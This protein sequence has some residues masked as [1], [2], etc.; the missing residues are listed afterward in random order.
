MTTPTTRLHLAIWPSRV[1]PAHWA[2][3]VPT[4]H[5]PVEGGSP[6]AMIGTILDVEGD[7]LHGFTH[8]V[9]PNYDLAPELDCGQAEF[10]PLGVAKFKQSNGTTQSDS[11]NDSDLV[12][13][14]AEAC[15]SVPPPNKSL[16]PTETHEF[17]SIEEAAASGALNGRG[18]RRAP[19]QTGQSWVRGVVNTLVD[20]GF[21][22]E[23]S[24]SM[25]A[26]APVR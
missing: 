1:F 18:V 9:R 8:R 21:L 23:E 20:R 25:I 6:T 2:I 15:L 4:E 17:S 26:S 13:V 19:V 5:A 12:G 22:E 10:Y 3:F 24:R 7:P 16:R 11:N 14:L